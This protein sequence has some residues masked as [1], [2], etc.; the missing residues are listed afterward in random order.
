MEEVSL[1]RENILLATSPGDDVFVLPPNT[2]SEEL[3]ARFTTVHAPS[4]TSYAT[5]NDLIDACERGQIY[6]PTEPTRLVSSRSPE[7][8]RINGL[9]ATSIALFSPVSDEER[10]GESSKNG[11]NER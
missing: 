3:D 10:K 1:E 5:I 9:A 7:D 2:A 11:T 6:Q 4:P 8:P